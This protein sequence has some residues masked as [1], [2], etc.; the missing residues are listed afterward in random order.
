MAEI[1]LLNESELRRAVDLDRAA[2]DCIED[3][4]LMLATEPVVMPPVLRLDLEDQHGEVDVKT[5][6]VPGLPGFAIKISPGFFDNPKKGL[7]SLNGLM[8]LFSTETGLVQAV[9]FDNGYLTDVRTAAAGAVAA[10]WL[11]PA[12]AQVAGIVG[13]G[14]QARLQLQAL[15]LVRQVTEV[16]VYARE[17]AKARTYAE[18]MGDLLQVPVRPVTS[19]QELVQVSDVVVTTT[20]ATSPLIR[21]EWLRPGQHITAMGSDAEHKNELH[22]GVI[23]RADRYVCDRRSQALSLGELHHAVAAGTVP[24]DLEVAELGQVIAGQREGR[25]SA[26]QITV[27]DLTGTGVQDTAIANFALGRALVAGAG[28]SFQS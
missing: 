20:P 18:E 28:A 5:A 8:V 6:Y 3:A 12:D 1:M 15:A 21:A 25:S 13:A 24:E 22:P 10:K 4:F 16:V 9:L 26:D 14:V 27:A 11:A 7:P 19:I 23:A 2:V 17:G